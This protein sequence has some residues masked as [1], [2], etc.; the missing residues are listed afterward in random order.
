MYTQDDD[1]EELLITT[2]KGSVDLGIKQ[3]WRFHGADMKQF[4]I[5]EEPAV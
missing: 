5:L 3:A 2:T 4:P 1:G